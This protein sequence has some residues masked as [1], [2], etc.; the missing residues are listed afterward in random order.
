MAEEGSEKENR[1][2]ESQDGSDNGSG[3]DS[4]DPP[5]KDLE[6]VLEQEK[7]HDTT[8]TQR[9]PP[10]AEPIEPPPE[11]Q[12]KPDL[13]RAESYATPPPVA[14]PRSERR[15]L[16]GRFTVLAEITEPKHYKRSD[17]W[18][19]TFV[20]ATSAMAAPTGSSIIFRTS[21]IL[22]FKRVFMAKLLL[23]PLSTR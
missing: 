11:K 16:F 2:R 1:P 9:I 20:V 17:K 4:H 23:Q 7:E 3:P 5:E 22:H 10:T 12:P 6:K 15:G 18:F 19:I 8:S 13:E 21:H 14:V